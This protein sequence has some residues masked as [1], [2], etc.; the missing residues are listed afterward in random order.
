MN[1]KE[2]IADFLLDLAKLV[3]GGVFLA[4]FMAEEINK[5]WIYICG[6]IVFALCCIV[7]FVFY[8]TIKTKED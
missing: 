6:T 8:K 3:F 7:A 4:G 1:I 5:V 2:K